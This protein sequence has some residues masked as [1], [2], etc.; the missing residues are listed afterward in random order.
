MRDYHGII[1]AYSASPELRTLVAH[2]TAA[3]LPFCGRYRLIDMALS[4]LRNAGILDVGVIM[5][6]DYQSLLDHIGSGKSWDMSRK[7]GGL[8]MLPPFGLPEYHR[9]E[10]A[11]TMEAL[12]AVASYIEDIPQKHVILLQ[13]NVCANIDLADVIRFHE[14]NHADMTAICAP[15]VK[16]GRYHYYSVNKDGFV[17]HIHFYREPGCEGYPSIEGYVVHKD[18]L[19]ELMKNCQSDRLYRF[20]RDA[21]PLFLEKGGKMNVYLHESYMSSIRSVDEYYK[22]NMDM[23]CSEK[24]RQIFPADRPVRAKPHDEVSSYYGEHAS[25]K[26]CLVADNCKI[27]GK[28]ENCIVFS[29]ARIAKG[30]KLNNCILMRGCTVGEG[31]ELSHVIVDKHST[32]NA[33]V[34]LVGSNKLPVVVP[35]FSNI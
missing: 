20:H 25:A 2:R 33:G 15:A 12:N 18:T 10:Y 13:G 3:S 9:G 8:R 4:S 1:F 21:I 6:R 24:R 17:D 23:L 16:E 14:N 19:L 35:K 32:I 29:G 31:A 27:E 11:G 34:K 28:L 5:Q 7:S 30:A 22:A 26:N